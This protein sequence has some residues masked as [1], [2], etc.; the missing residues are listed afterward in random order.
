MLSR[1]VN[2]FTH[3]GLPG[4]ARRCLI[5]AD[6]LMEHG[7]LQDA[8]K[9]AVKARD[10]KGANAFVVKLA[11]GKIAEIS[12]LLDTQSGKSTPQPVKK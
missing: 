3:F 12:N 7:H 11:K 10:A 2:N 6:G 5:K 8:L 4:T 1:I 9:E